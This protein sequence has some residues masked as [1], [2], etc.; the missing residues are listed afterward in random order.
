[1]KEE[2]SDTS[3]A[4]RLRTHSTYTT[5]SDEKHPI[6]TVIEWITIEGLNDVSV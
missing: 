4:G 1:M 5:Q 6:L 3:K 2:M